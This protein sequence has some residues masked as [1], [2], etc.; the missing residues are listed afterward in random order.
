MNQPHTNAIL[1]FTP[2]EDLTGKE[3]LAVSING[4]DGT[5]ALTADFGELPH[6]IIILGTN[7]D[8]KSSIAMV[9]G[10]VTGTVKIK[11][12]STVD[13]GGL[14]QHKQD[15]FIASTNSPMCCAQALESG[16]SGEFVEA[17]LFAATTTDA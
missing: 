13:A 7:T 15:G 17:V 4:A 5:V 16:A 1:P 9:Y 2:S 11:L 6:G 8:E 14:M 3:G 10:G 12:N